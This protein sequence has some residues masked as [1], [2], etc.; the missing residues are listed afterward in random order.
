MSF[1]RKF[2]VW[3]LAYAVVGMSLGIFMAASHNHA[4]HVT[5]AHILLVGFVLTLVYGVIH[6]LWL[7]DRARRLAMTHFVVHHAGAITLFVGL[8]LLYGNMVEESR[9]DPVLGIASITVLS[10]VLLMLYMVVKTAGAKA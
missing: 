6:K 8:F 5:H 1:D 2:L 7:G 9:L 3:A 4:E 10:G